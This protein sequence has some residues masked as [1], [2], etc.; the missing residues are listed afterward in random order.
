M[1]K[2]AARPG[3]TLIVFALVV[4]AM[5]VGLAATN[6]WKPKLGLDL[7]GGTRITLRAS[8]ATGEAITPDKLK[9]AAG[10]VDSRVNG[11]GVAESEVST[12]GNRNIVVEIPGQNRKDLVD[13]VKQTAQLRFRLVAAS[14][15]GTPAP[16]QQ[17]S[18][19]PSSGG[20]KASKGAGKADK[21]G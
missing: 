10:I 16:T 17:A 1:A 15:P 9:E 2:N 20:G 11:S 7:Q 18:A 3:R 21:S 12:Q 14:A 13:T 4:L 8:T 6:T 5:Y 19:T